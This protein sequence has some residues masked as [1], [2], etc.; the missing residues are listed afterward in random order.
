M[1]FSAVIAAS[2]MSVVGIGNAIGKFSFG[3]L[4][5]I[6]LPPK[7]ILIIGS[8]LE[9]GGTFIL[10][11]LTSSSPS[12]MLWLYALM[13]GFGVGCWFPAISLT[14]SANF[15]PI[16][17]GSVVSI[18]NMLFM[19]MGAVAPWMGRYIFD[20]TGSYNLA[21][22]LCFIF[23]AIAVG[24]MLFVPRARIKNNAERRH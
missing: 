5:D 10:M 23:Y 4:C 6:C 16:A 15:S 12:A 8:A 1:G 13:F 24:A 3:W 7:Y 17:Y 14:T 20:T 19:V 22:Q 2:A 9:A 11:S 21:F 18:Y